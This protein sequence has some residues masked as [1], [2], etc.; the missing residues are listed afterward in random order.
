MSLVCVCRPLVVAPAIATKTVQ[1]RPIIAMLL[2][3]CF[4]ICQIWGESPIRAAERAEVPAERSVPHGGP[5]RP[6]RD[7]R[8]TGTLH[9]CALVP[10]WP[11]GTCKLRPVIAEAYISHN[12]LWCPCHCSCEQGG[13]VQQHLRWSIQLTTACFQKSTRTA[14]FVVL[15]IFVSLTTKPFR[16]VCDATIKLINISCP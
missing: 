1:W 16:F 14:V 3:F 9:A 5:H 2:L 8:G 15:I 12:A 10:V 11:E 6:R 4:V 7:Q 13:K